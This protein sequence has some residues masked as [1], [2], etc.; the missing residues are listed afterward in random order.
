MFPVP[1]LRLWRPV[2]YWRVRLL[3]LFC[4]AEAVAG[5]RNGLFREWRHSWW[6]ERGTLRADGNGA[7]VWQ[8]ARQR[9]QTRYWRPQLP[10]TTQRKAAS[11]M[12]IDIARE[13]GTRLA[14]GDFGFQCLVKIPVRQI[15]HMGI[16]AVL[17]C[18]RQINLFA[19]NM[20]MHS[21]VLP[22]LLQAG[23]SRLN[24]EPHGVAACFQ[25]L[26][27]LTVNH[28]AMDSA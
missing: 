3:C 5:H 2:F 1:R 12:D 23:P 9:H 24:H 10:F 21:D 18:V 22:C 27:A 11:G 8:Y 28:A 14:E 4:S 7:A 13:K 17:E 6:H 16:D 15:A 26:A 25:A 19:G 20:N